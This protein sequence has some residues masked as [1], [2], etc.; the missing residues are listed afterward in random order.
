MKLIVLGGSGFVG[1]NILKQMDA[2]EKA[3][4]SRNN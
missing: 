4:F 1:S 3:Y 2:E